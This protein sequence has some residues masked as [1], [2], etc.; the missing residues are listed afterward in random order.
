MQ[1]RWNR[2]RIVAILFALSL[3]AVDARADDWPQWLGPKRDGVWRETG[4]LAKFPPGG[5]KVRWRTPI[6]EGYSGPSVANGKVYVT[7]RVAANNPKSGFSKKARVAGN[8]RVLCLNEADGKIIWKHEYPCDYQI[9]YPSGPRT[10][11]LVSG[12]KVYTLGAM[13]HLFCFDADTGK[14]LWSKELLDAYKYN[15]NTWGFSAHP[16]IDGD[17]LIC[18]VGGKGSVVV[19]FHKDTGKEIWKALSAKDPGYSPPMIYEINGKRQLVVWHPESINALN[20]ETGKVY[21]TQ[22][23]GAKKFNKNGLTVSSSR[24]D[25]D[26]LFFTAFYDGPLMLQINS[27]NQ[28]RILW[29]GN[30]RGEQPGDTDGLHSIMPTPVIKD[31]HIYGVCSYGELRCLEEATGKRLWETHQATT[32][33]ST[34]WGN[35]FLVEQGDRFILFNERGD[36]IIAKLTPKGYDEISRA[37][38]LTPTNRMPGRPVIWSHPA[39]ANRCVYARSDTEIVCVSMAE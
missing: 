1:I 33:E 12:G 32:G 6:G 17:R 39:F 27:D 37:N 9:D 18:L 19:A 4:I 14:I 31:G 34:R 28:P 38:I 23:Y 30:G 2:A 13:G 10:S 21:W 3:A 20:P 25:R 5:P 7:D 15:N 29:Q 26:K 36:L 11:P 22:T 24:F 35:A 16:L 8:E